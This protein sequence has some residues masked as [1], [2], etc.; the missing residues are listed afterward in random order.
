MFAPPTVADTKRKFTEAYPYHPPLYNNVL[1]ELIVQQH[2][3]LGE[4]YTFDPVMALGLITV[5]EQLMDG[6][7]NEEARAAVFAAY[8]G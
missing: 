3:T 1:Q 2:F 5:F 8:V 4:D 7:R 6:Y